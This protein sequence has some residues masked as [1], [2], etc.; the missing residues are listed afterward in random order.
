M[1]VNRYMHVWL[2]G[3]LPMS[4]CGR[5]D[6]QSASSAI[7]TQGTAP[8]SSLKPGLNYWNEQGQHFVFGQWRIEII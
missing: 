6:L 1:V 4:I 3:L 7:I 8:T 2:L 5:Q